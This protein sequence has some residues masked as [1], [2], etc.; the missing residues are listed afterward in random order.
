MAKIKWSAVGITNASGKSGGSV[1]SFNRAGAY[2]R[3]WA[4]PVNA[5]SQRQQAMRSMWGTVS[6]HWGSVLTADQ[7]SAWSEEAKEIQVSDGFGDV[8]NMTGFTYF[9]R[10]NFNRLHSMGLGLL[11]LPLPK[12]TLPNFGQVSLVSFDTTD[13][14]IAVQLENGGQTSSVTVTVAMALEPQGQGL[15]IGS[16]KNKFSTLGRKNVTLTSGSGALTFDDTDFPELGTIVQ[17]QKAF[18]SLHAHTASGQKSAP[19]NFEAI[20]Q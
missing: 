14:E 7:R 1:F 2:V 17:G 16:V 5:Q 18:F 6:Q 3:R 11:T 19:F 4:K 8:R 9:M 12:E 15:S 20:L 10:V 13:R